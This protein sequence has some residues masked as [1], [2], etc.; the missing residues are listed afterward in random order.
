MGPIYRTIWYV[1]TRCCGERFRAGRS[2]LSYPASM[3]DSENDAPRLP[4]M[5]TRWT[6]GD[7]AATNEVGMDQ[8]V[9]ERYCK[10]GATPTLLR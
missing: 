10:L 1:V 2:C 5:T 6:L 9:A 3:S 8:R 4:K 7:G